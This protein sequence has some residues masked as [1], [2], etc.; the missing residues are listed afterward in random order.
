[1]VLQSLL[2]SFILFHWVNQPQKRWLP[3]ALSTAF[4]LAI[5]LPVLGL[6]TK[7]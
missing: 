6:V 1:V 5:L 4:G 3:W 7:R 2:F